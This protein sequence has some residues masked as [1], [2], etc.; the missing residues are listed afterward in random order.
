MLPCKR[1]SDTS[2]AN[3]DAPLPAFD[4]FDDRGR[5][6]TQVTVNASGPPLDADRFRDRGGAVETD[7]DGTWWAEFFLLPGG[8]ELDFG[9]MYVAAQV[10]SHGPE[11][12][13]THW[14]LSFLRAPGG[15]VPSELRERA[16]AGEFPEN[17]KEFLDLGRFRGSVDVTARA[18]YLLS[19]ERFSDAL[20]ALCFR[21][22]RKVGEV[23]MHI[24]SCSWQVKGLRSLKRM[25][26]Q[27]AS[28]QRAALLS[29]RAELD[30]TISDKLVEDVDH[31]L[32]DEVTRCLSAERSIADE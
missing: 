22:T 12:D 21:R 30:V 6:L 1:V 26:L 3:E 7:E 27:Q 28:Y 15:T 4:K 23:E 9:T 29:T 2:S 19:E 5:Y 17:F 10:H 31:V 13:E 18:S 20:D 11:H 14:E 24:G 25:T 16:F 32:W 8:A